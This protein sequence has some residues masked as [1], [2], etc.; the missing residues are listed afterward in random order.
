[1]SSTAAENAIAAAP[2]EVLTSAE[3]AEYLRVSEEALLRAVGPVGVPARLIDGEWRFLKSALQE[4][5]CTDLKPSSR[6]SLL[7]VA[8]AWKDD[9]YLDEMLKEIYRQRGRPM[10][11]TD[12]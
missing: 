10:T 5:L 9:P 11:E 2:A 8:G 3:A 1:M 4:W 6:E 7:S 12:E